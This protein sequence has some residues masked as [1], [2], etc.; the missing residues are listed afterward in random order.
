MATVL[1]T[2]LTH[3]YHGTSCKMTHNLVTGAAAV[4]VTR[5]WVITL[6]TKMV[7]ENKENCPVAGGAHN[8]VTGTAAVPVTRLWVSYQVM[9]H[10][11]CNQ[12]GD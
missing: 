3:N 12:N 7:T 4:P 11:P 2:A 1:G 8:L 6:A 9:D 5:L 10:Y